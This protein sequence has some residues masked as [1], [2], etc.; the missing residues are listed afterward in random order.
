MFDE[1]DPRKCVDIL[2][3]DD[4]S[5]ENQKLLLY[6]IAIEGNTDKLSLESVEVEERIIDNDGKT[7]L[8]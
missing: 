1:C 5:V 4:N 3:A 7:D 2:I 8:Y 6:G